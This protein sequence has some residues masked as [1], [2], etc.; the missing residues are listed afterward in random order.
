MALLGDIRSRPDRPFVVLKYAQTLDGRIATSTGD[1]K[2]ISGVAER[3]VSHALRAACDAVLVGVGT[4][5]SDDPELTVRMVSGASPMRV[6]LD[7]NLRISSDAKILG[8]DAAT[9]VITTERSDPA[10]RAA[11]RERGVRVEVVA[12][13]AGRVSL[14]AALATLRASGTESVL[15]EGGSEMITGLLAAGLVDRII[16]GVAPVVIGS[17]TQAVNDLRVWS[18]ADGIRL[19]NRS[20]LP[21]GEDVVL[22][23]DVVGPEQQS[24]N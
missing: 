2:W 9:T 21:V 5:M 7:S 13:Q 6:V 24:I 22:A 4:V 17:G 3:R 1:S 12:E 8:P 18:V 19:E 14:R 23:W 11:L 16:V 15:V 10:R 20:I